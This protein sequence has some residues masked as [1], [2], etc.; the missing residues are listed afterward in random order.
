MQQTMTTMIS[1]IQARGRGATLAVVVDLHSQAPGSAAVVAAPV[2][3]HVGI[4][5]DDDEAEDA[6][7][8]VGQSAS[9]EV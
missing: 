6:V 1:A 3:G 7:R 4:I 2:Y 9:L 5:A 8:T